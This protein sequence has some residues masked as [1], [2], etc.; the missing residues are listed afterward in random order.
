MQG[1]LCKTIK[2]SNRSDS[3][4][5]C[6]VPVTDS[7]CTY[8]AAGNRKCSK[9]LSCRILYF[10]VVNTGM[11]HND[12]HTC[13]CTTLV[14]SLCSSSN[15]GT[16]AELLLCN[17]SRLLPVTAEPSSFQL[18]GKRCRKQQQQPHRRL[19]HSG[20]YRQHVVQLYMARSPSHT[21]TTAATS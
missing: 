18:S 15:S 14:R 16:S 17:S 21:S 1:S 12:L 8:P 9:A 19:Q 4:Q 10:G 5:A 13:N 7:C 2:L 3:T 11:V 6:T 20:M